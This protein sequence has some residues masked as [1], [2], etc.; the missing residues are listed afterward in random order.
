MASHSHLSRQE[1]ILKKLALVYSDILNCIKIRNTGHVCVTYKLDL[2]LAIPKQ[3][4]MPGPFQGVSSSIPILPPRR[5]YA[6]VPFSGQMR[7]LKKFLPGEVH[8]L[9][10]LFG[11]WLLIR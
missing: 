2:S 9:V 8:F 3:L 5:S 10:Q 7:Y 6:Y 1:P 4:L 11:V